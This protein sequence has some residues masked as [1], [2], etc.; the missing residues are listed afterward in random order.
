MGTVLGVGLLAPKA[1]A[2]PKYSDC[3]FVMDVEVPLTVGTV[4]T[5]PF[6]VKSRDYYILLRMQDMNLPLEDTVCLLGTASSLPFRLNC[7]K[8]S[9]IEGAWTV[10]DGT[11]KAVEGSF[12]GGHGQG[13]IAEERQL[14]Q[15]KG[16]PKRNYTLEV[17]F[18]KDGG[19]LKAMKP[20][21]IVRKGYDFWCGPM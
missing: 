17:T 5:P 18:T 14:G 16:Q 3:S 7:N 12:G 4:R 1:W 8:E 6:P 20:H 13:E 19:L 9:V 10:W 15:F 11:E 2:R 21:L